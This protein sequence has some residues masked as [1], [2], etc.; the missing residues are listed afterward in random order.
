MCMFPTLN[1]MLIYT[2]VNS[3]ILKILFHQKYIPSGDHMITS[4][5]VKGNHHVK[6]I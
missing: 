2:A 5:N 6:I 3:F 4:N 1:N